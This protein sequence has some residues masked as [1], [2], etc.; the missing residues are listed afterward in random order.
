MTAPALR[1]V[2]GSL[3]KKGN[4]ASGWGFMDGGNMLIISV[5]ALVGGYAYQYSS[6]STLYILMSTAF[7]I[8]SLLL[9]SLSKH[10]AKTFNRSGSN[11]D[12]S[13]E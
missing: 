3:L 4:L 2:Y 1:V 11:I 6:S 12:I 5:A 9:F 8:S 7:G 10:Y 13:T